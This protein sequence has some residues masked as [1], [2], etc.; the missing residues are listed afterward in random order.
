MGA[1]QVVTVPELIDKLKH[2][3]LAKESCI[4]TMLT[5]TRRS[6]LMRFSDGVLT[7]A[8]CRSWEIA[9]TIEALLETHP[10]HIRVYLF[11]DLVAHQSYCQTASR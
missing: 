9:F 6:V 10:S 11:T 7:S 2:I 5:D 4:I 3:I 1:S 8:R